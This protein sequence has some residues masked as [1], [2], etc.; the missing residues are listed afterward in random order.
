[1]PQRTTLINKH[2]K[3]TI[4]QIDLIMLLKIKS[5]SEWFYYNGDRTISL[6]ERLFYER[7]IG[8]TK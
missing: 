2:I 1:M 4:R 3:K 8:V 7:K 6:L 5:I